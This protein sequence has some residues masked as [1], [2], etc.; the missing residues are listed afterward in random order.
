MYYNSFVNDGSVQ[1]GR[2]TTLSYQYVLVETGEYI[3]VEK[4]GSVN[5]LSM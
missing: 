3:L 2:N 4:A 5:N 1:I